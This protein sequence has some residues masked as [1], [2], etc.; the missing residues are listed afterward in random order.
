MSQIHRSRPSSHPF[1]D[2]VWAS[3]NLT[4]GIYLATPDG[5]W[6]LI[7]GIQA[8]GS[9]SMIIAGQATKPAYI[10]Y[11]AGTSSVVISFAAGV[12]MP[13]IPAKSLLDTVKVLPVIDS[14]HFELCGHPFTFPTFDTAEDLVNEMSK[15]GIL[16]HNDLVDSMLNGAPKA[17]SLRAAQRHFLHTTGTTQKQLQQI[18]RAKSAVR[19]LQKGKKPI[20]VAADTGFTDQPHLANSLKKIMHSKPSHVDDIHKL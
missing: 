12:Y 13:Q 14:G 1:I 8:D 9:R 5:S 17:V 10:P 4:D 6:D 3:Q 15:L 18:Q 19:Q 16:A 2:T 7:L 11:T 20:E